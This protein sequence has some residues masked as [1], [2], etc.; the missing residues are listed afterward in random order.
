M[1]GRDMYRAG[2]GLGVLLCGGLA[3]LVVYLGLTRNPGPVEVADDFLRLLARGKTDRA[4]AYAAPAMRAHWTSSMFML[5]AQEMGLD[6]YASSSW[7][8]V[9]V[10]D[11][12]ARL[13]G[14]ITT[15]GGDVIPL[16][17]KLV[18]HKE[19]WCILSIGSP[20]PSENDG[21]EEGGATPD[22]R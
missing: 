3:T 11:N 17:I 8:E 5:R 9:H 12:D 16:V 19:R 18:R 10:T 6:S 7:D 2:C 20:P 1:D 15:K 14:N 13:Q 4:F 21:A 22:D